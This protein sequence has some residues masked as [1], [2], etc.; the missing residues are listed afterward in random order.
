MGIL[1][2]CKAWLDRLPV[3]TQLEPVA[4]T[5]D[6]HAELSEPRSSTADAV[7]QQTRQS[8]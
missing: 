4:V 7:P 8:P 2:S 6:G 5:T 1:E 3:G